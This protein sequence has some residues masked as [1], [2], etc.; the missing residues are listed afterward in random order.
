MVAPKGNNFAVGNKGGGR[1]GYEHEKEQLGLMR[2]IVSRDLKLVKKI[3][4]GKATQE[5]FKKLSAL[6]LRVAKYLDK[7]HVPASEFKGDI[8]TKVEIDL[9]TKQKIKEA[10]DKI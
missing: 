10:L 5:D 2:K 1:K 9:Q 6:Q 4:D 3:Y 8:T 7:L